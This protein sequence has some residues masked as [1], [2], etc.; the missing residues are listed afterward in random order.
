MAQKR[1]IK[2]LTEEGLGQTEIEN[3]HRAVGIT[4]QLVITSDGALVIGHPGAVV[5]LFDQFAPLRV[6]PAELVSPL[7]RLANQLVEKAVELKLLE[8]A[9]HH[10]QLGGQRLGA[11]LLGVL[12]IQV[13]GDGAHNILLVSQS[14][15][16]NRYGKRTKPP[17]AKPNGG[18]PLLRQGLWP[19]SERGVSRRPGL[20][21]KRPGSFAHSSKVPTPAGS[22]VAGRA[23]HSSSGN[24][25]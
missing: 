16:P 8:L 10:A 7:P 24:A 21:P 18:S 1:A 19:G 12:H 25:G 15:E 6:G 11:D 14:G 9:F 2:A 4:Q 17:Q 3:L 22:L 13:I 23:I 20:P 5:G